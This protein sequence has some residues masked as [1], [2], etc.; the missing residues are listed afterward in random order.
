MSSLNASS[1]PETDS[2]IHTD[3]AKKDGEVIDPTETQIKARLHQMIGDPNVP[4]KILSTFRWNINDQVAE[5][6]QKGR[7]L[8]IGDAVHR[9]PP[10]NGL[11]S[12]TCMADA[13]NLAWKIAY[14]LQGY[15]GKGLLKTLTVERKPV[16]DGIVRRANTGMVCHRCNSLRILAYMTY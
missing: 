2:L 9:H 16:G 11:G 8:C 14:V 5:T 1:Q 13:F 4:I 10:I 6:W 3:P 12:N 15:A 7:V